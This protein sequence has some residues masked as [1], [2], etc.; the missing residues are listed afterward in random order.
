MPAAAIDLAHYSDLWHHGEDHDWPRDQYNGDCTPDPTPEQVEEWHRIADRTRKDARPA[1]S[2]NYP[3]SPDTK[4]STSLSTECATPSHGS[5]QRTGTEERVK[6]SPVRMTTIQE[7]QEMSEKWG[8]NQLFCTK[9]TVG[10]PL[11]V[12]FFRA[13]NTIPP[14]FSPTPLSPLFTSFFA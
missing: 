10:R 13:T 7:K 4:S 6:K 5:K 9:R 14:I 2:R 3:S 1:R 12:A 8:P 11:S